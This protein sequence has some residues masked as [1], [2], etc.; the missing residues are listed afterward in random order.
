M[1]FPKKQNIRKTSIILLISPFH[2]TD[3]SYSVILRRLQLNYASREQCS[4]VILFIGLIKT[5]KAHRR[6]ER[7]KRF[8]FYYSLLPFTLTCYTQ[9][10]MH[11]GKES[12]TAPP[13]FFFLVLAFET[14]CYTC[15]I[16]WCVRIRI[17]KER[18]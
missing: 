7:K 5:S 3:P 9:R 15:F 1:L 17:K 6:H 4:V 18:E 2:V 14:S 11:K 8:L 13:P 16:T 10:W 12:F